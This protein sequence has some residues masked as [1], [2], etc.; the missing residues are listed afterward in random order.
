MNKKSA[1]SLLFHADAN[2]P[3]ML[4]FSR[5]GAFDPYLAFTSG[6]KK[7]GVAPVVEYGRMTKESAFDEVI[8]LPDVQNGAARR[9][10]L[11]NG[12]L[13]NTSQLVQQNRVVFEDHLLMV[14]GF[15]A[16][17]SQLMIVVGG[18]GLAATM[19]LSVL[20]RTREIGVMRAIGARHEAILLMVYI[21]GL[22][23]AL[24]SWVLAVPLSVPMSVLLARAFARIMIPVPITWVPSMMSVGVWLVVVI[25]VTVVSCSWPAWRALRVTTARALQYE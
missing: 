9:F 24:A 20:E 6:G 25:S 13:P 16:I 21:E 15:L 18:L 2:D 17:M 23:I 11:H 19:S 7:F 12:N 22:V 1:P 14:A 8:Y 4:H 3:D 10:K 5:F